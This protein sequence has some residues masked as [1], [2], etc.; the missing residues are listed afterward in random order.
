MTHADELLVDGLLT[1]EHSEN[2]GVFLLDFPYHIGDPAVVADMIGVEAGTEI[3]TGEKLQVI[4]PASFRNGDALLVVTGTAD[5]YG[6]LDQFDKIF[7]ELVRVRSE[8]ASGQC[9]RLVTITEANLISLN[10]IVTSSS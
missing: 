2:G 1:Y 9:W 7:P 6:G 10:K 5:P 3:V 8:I 4:A